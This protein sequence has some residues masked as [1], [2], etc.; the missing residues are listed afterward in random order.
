[1]FNIIF[2][3]FIVKL[4]VPSFLEISVIVVPEIYAK[5]AGII[6]KI[7]G[8]TKEPIPANAATAIVTSLIEFHS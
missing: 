7:Q 2:I 4:T 6:G 3:L 1:M 8:A 5:N